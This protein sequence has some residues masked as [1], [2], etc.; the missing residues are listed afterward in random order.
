VTA[1]NSHAHC[2]DKS[3]LVTT[4]RHEM[5]PETATVDENRVEGGTPKKVSGNEQAGATK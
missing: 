4:V 3:K 5:P 2:T 1:N